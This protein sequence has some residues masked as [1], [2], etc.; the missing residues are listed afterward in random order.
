MMDKEEEISEAVMAMIIVV[1][2]TLFAGLI[3][4]LSIWSLRRFFLVVLSFF[5]VY[6]IYDR[7]NKI[8]L[9]VS[10]MDLNI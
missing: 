4:I 8:K 7:N 6:Y 10:K 2:F 3:V 1:T 5:F 9:M